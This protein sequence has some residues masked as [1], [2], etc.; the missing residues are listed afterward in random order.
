MEN[1][2]SSA[3][4]QYNLSLLNCCHRYFSCITPL[5]SPPTTLFFSCRLTFVSDLVVCLFLLS[6]LQQIFFKNISPLPRQAFR[7]DFFSLDQAGV[8]RSDYG[9]FFFVPFGVSGFREF[10]STSGGGRFVV[11]RGSAICP[12]SLGGPPRRTLD[13]WKCQSLDCVTR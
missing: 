7:V 4:S 3:V 13:R 10:W 9:S 12:L 5:V 11:L 2:P 6:S 8:Y 1:T